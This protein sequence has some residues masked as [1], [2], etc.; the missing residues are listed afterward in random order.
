M[1]ILPGSDWIIA[2]VMGDREGAKFHINQALVIWLAGLLGIIP[3]VGWIWGIFCFV[4]AVMGCISAINGEEKEVP[5]LGKIKLLK[6]RKGAL[7]AAL[8]F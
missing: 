3:C 6:W 5:L 8:F 1:H 2:L 7:D 4:C